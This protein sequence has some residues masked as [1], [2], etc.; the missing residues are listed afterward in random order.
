MFATTTAEAKACCPGGGGGGGG[1]AP[2]KYVSAEGWVANAQNGPVSSAH[3]WIVWPILNSY[4]E[5]ELSNTV[6]T[7]IQIA[8]GDGDYSFSDFT[9]ANGASCTGS[10]AIWASPVNNE[11]YWTTMDLN[12]PDSQNMIVDDIYLASNFDTWIS[13]VAAYPNVADT[14]VTYTS[15]YS[16]EATSSWSVTG[17]IGSTYG[18]YSQTQ[19]GT[20]SVTVS[21]T[22]T[23]VF[24]TPTIVQD[25]YSV[26]GVIDTENGG[27]DPVIADLYLTNLG[28]VQEV[29]ATDPVSASSVLG[30]S[31]CYSVIGTNTITN[32]YAETASTTGESTYNPS[33]SVP[34]DGVTLSL[35][36]SLS[37]TS[38][39]T[40][41]KS[42]S[43]TIT[44]DGSS[45]P[46][47]YQVYQTTG[48]LTT[49]LWGPY[50]SEP[51][52]CG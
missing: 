38:Q 24:N 42:V 4:G 52:G 23:Y 5:C 39:D 1:G 18:G 41:S 29:S 26:N 8:N 16:H 43:Y 46:Q 12:Q 37:W 31:N 2:P 28:N 44:G 35:S 30:S 17:N 7:A 21:Y 19:S 50:S 22:S 3:V 49:H 34:I 25:Q 45:S 47:W 20:T 32:A 40:S 15:G 11:P 9:E 27:T 14:S 13:A 33:L 6:S 48:D 10:Y 36:L 51:S